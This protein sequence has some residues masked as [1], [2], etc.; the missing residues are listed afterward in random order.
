MTRTTKP[1]Q[2]FGSH[3]SIAWTKFD[4][5]RERN[6]HQKSRVAPHGDGRR[7]SPTERSRAES[8]PERSIFCFLT[9]T[10]HSTSHASD[11]NY[12]EFVHRPWLVR[13]D[14]ATSQKPRRLFILHLVCSFFGDQEA[15]HE[16]FAAAVYVMAAGVDN[17]TC[18][19]RLTTYPFVNLR[20]CRS[21]VKR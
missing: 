18:L 12:P 14:H 17:R 11:G 19:L 13:K 9:T 3:R 8:I 21:N 1:S 7:V 6:L 5:F 16:N 4:S 2:L 20:Q 10:S 15:V